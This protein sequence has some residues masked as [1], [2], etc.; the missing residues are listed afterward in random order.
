MI[1]K[2]QKVKIIIIFLLIFCS[3]LYI[4]CPTGKSNPLDQIYECWPSYEFEYNQTLCDKPV[5][6]YSEPRQ[7][8]ITVKAKISGPNPDIVADKIGG[9]ILIVDISIAEISEG[10]HAS[11]NPPT[12]LFPVS[13][14]YV[15]ANATLSFT[16]DQYFDAFSLKKIKISL[17]N[18]K[19][20]SKTTLVKSLTRNFN[21]SFSVGYEPRLS[22]SY[23]ENNVKSINPGEIAIFPIDIENWGNDV[24]TV[25]IEIIDIPNGWQANIIKNLTLSTNLFGK[26][27]KE[28]VML[29]VKPPINFGYH[30]DRAVIKVKITPVSFT[31]K[32]FKG[33]PQ[34]LYFIVQSEGFSTPGFEMIFAVFAFIFILLPFCRRK[35]IKIQNK[36][37]RG[38]NK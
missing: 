16:I 11:I 38:R 27:A 26:E 35:N 3:S 28:N 1:K 22:F 37:F 18:E 36:Q 34:Y 30:E 10:C 5:I 17:T 9:V 33:E 2:F 13:D 15:I 21:I 6:P 12:I 20:G 29:N 14:E 31:N 32:S 4:L 19:L 24:T 7:I 25:N 8:P 23:P